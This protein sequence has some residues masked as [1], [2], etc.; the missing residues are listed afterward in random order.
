MDQRAQPCK[1]RATDRNGVFFAPPLD[2]LALPA[3]V[4]R[5]D[6]SLISSQDSQGVRQTWPGPSDTVMQVVPLGHAELSWQRISQLL[7]SG[8]R[9]PAKP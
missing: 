5:P 9:V 1:G 8:P 6:H 2:R 3:H 4:S 7:N